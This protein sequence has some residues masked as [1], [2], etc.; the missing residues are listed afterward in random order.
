[1]KAELNKLGAAPRAYN[2][3]LAMEGMSIEGSGSGRLTLTE[4]F[5]KI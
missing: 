1:M 5:D 3:R 2:E 4:R